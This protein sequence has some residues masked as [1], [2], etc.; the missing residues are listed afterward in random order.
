MLGLRLIDS[1]IIIEVRLI[2][3][4]RLIDKPTVDRQTCICLGVG[5]RV[6]G[7]VSSNVILLV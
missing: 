3:S 6:I 4:C 2:G 1:L 5:K 7:W